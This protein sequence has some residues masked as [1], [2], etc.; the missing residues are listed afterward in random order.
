M[1]LYYI[2]IWHYA[3]L[4]RCMGWRWDFKI[5]FGGK[6]GYLYGYGHKGKNMNIY[7]VISING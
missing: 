7:M 3:L 5:F 1:V 4:I 2:I 6:Q